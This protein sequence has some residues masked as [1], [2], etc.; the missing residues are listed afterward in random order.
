MV[1]EIFK[2]YLSYPTYMNCKQSFI[3][4]IITPIANAQFYCIFRALLMY[5]TILLLVGELSVV[6]VVASDPSSTVTESVVQPRII[7]GE[8]APSGRYP[9]V[10]S[11][12][13][14]SF[15]FCGGTYRKRIIETIT[16]ANNRAK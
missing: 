7:G 10:V 6:V 11:L 12:T 5:S 2:E 9:F 1:P 8:Q 4:S 14:N 3:M 13:R 15:A 16:I